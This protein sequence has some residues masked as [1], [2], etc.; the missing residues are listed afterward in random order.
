MKST[1]S[2]K[3]ALCLSIVLTF[4]WSVFAQTPAPTPNASDDGEVIKVDSRLVVI[5]VSVT[6]S[7]GE[8]VLGLKAQD[9]RVAED[10]K[11]QV[12]D[13]VGDAEN[14]PLEIALLVDVSGSVNP[15]FEFEKKAAAQFLQSV[16]KPDDRATIFLIGD[17]PQSA[18]TRENASQAATRLQ[19][20][21]LSGK[22]T[23]F[24]DTVL[25]A[26]DFLQKN[27]PVKSRKVV[28]ALTDGEDNWSDLTRE[29]E[30]ATYRDV[31]INSLTAEKR[32]Q[33]AAKTDAAH[34]NAQKR[35]LLGLQNAD[36]VFY[37]INPAGGSFRL[38]KISLRAQN[39]MQA[40]A[41]ETGGTAYLPKFQPLETKDALQNTSNAKKNEATLEQIFRQLANELRAQYL[42]QY[43]SEAEY[44]TNKYVKLSIALQNPASRKLRA[45]QGYYVKN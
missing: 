6:D 19:T 23:A 41:D 9:F 20:V 44:P 7:A 22:F 31:D 38:N 14:V 3:A 28:L 16:M 12:I 18:K 25:A 39:G 5:P 33:L 30:K 10:G 42:V 45:R 4:A 36:T 27:A 34:R 17:K 24:Y 32:N 43:Y 29:A 2:Q 15:L 8:P 37:A 26:A 13:Q 40:F 35:I 21:S 11:Q 1:R